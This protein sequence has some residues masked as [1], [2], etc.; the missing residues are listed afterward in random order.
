M[1]FDEKVVKR[2]KE[3][4]ETASDIIKD[5]DVVKLRKEENR[6]TKLSYDLETLTGYMD[7]LSAADVKEIQELADLIIV[8]LTDKTMSGE[9]TMESLRSLEFLT[10]VV[11]ILSEV[12]AKFGYH[13]SQN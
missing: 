1:D 2:I 5:A 9:I 10:D 11:S 4:L 8:E 12:S 13:L 6:F 7:S 3:Q